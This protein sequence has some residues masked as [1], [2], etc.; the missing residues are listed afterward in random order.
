LG[1]STWFDSD[2]YYFRSVGGHLL[3]TPNPNYGMEIGD[4]VN[5]KDSFFSDDGRYYMVQQEWSNLD[6]KGIIPNGDV[7]WMLD[8]PVYPPVAFEYVVHY[9]W[10]NGGRYT[11]YYLGIG[12]DGRV[13]E[14]FVTAT[15]DLSGWYTL[16]T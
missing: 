16:N 3:K 7:P 6:G 8:M 14:T 2:P 9:N 13:Y 11:S 10:N 12:V 4:I 5:R 15:G 1:G